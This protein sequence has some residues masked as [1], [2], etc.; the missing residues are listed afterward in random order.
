MLHRILIIVCL[1]ISNAAFARWATFEDA[2]VAVLLNN[3]YINVHADGTTEEIHEIKVKVLNEQGRDDL[4]TRVITYNH[5]NSTMQ[6]LEAKTIN[7]DQEFPVDSQYIEDKPLASQVH[8]FDQQHQL[9]LAFPNVNVGSII[10]FKYKFN[11]LKPDLKNFYE[12]MWHWRDKYFDTTH[13]A[14]KSE[15]PLYFNINNPDNKLSVQQGK[16]GKYYTLELQ[17]TRPSFVGVVDER[18]YLI[19]PSKYPWI[20]VATTK[21]W[22]DFARRYSTSYEK[23]LHQEL[24]DLYQHIAKQAKLQTDPSKQICEVAAML[25]ESIKYMGDWKTNNGRHVPQ[26]FAQ[27]ANTRLGDCKDYA[28]GMVAILRAMDFSANVALVERGNTVYDS[29]IIKLPGASHF[30]HAIVR[31]DLGN[32][33]LWV[34]PTN[35]FSIADVILP[36]IADRQAVVLDGK[37]ARLEHVPQ[38]G[39]DDRIMTIKREYNVVNDLLVD[40]RGS[41]DLHGLDAIRYTGTELQVTRDT[42]SNDVI[43]TLDNYD[44]IIDKHVDLPDLKSR[45]V[46]DILINFTYSVRNSVLQTNAGKAIL[47]TEPISRNYMFNNE[48]VADVY[49]GP[50]GI[51]REIIKI[52]NAHPV[53]TLPLDCIIK[54][55]WVDM[56]VSVKYDKDSI[57]IES[58][59]VMKASWL[60]NDTIRSD[61]YRKLE[62]DLAKN[63]RNGI[64][65]VFK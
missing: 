27:I 48:Q 6:V 46:K 38:S 37:N 54:S 26:D 39:V 18:S 44:N 56:Q 14:I 11:L 45:I 35:F 4:T 34:D 31:V 47:Y 43:N 19:S 55:P 61:S 49:L 63:F 20:Y 62:A 1:V 15:L 13:I 9:L 60:Y 2:P 29:S 17:Q 22:Q 32:K 58:E 8:G 10:Y 40:V 64:A 30:N 24:P 5:D 42:I 57:T 25:N 33:V 53:N 50:P 23:V 51:R 65:V 16:T 52:N 21:N 12:S 3:F 7:G 59:T 28:T 36:D 41:I